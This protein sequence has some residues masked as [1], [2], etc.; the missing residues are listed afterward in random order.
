MGKKYFQNDPDFIQKGKNILKN[1]VTIEDIV[2]SEEK[3]K[4]SSNIGFIPIELSLDI[5]GMSGIKIYNQLRLNTDFLPYNYPKV[6]E[7]VVMGIN[8]KVDSSGWSTSIN[9]IAKP[10]S[11]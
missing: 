10:K 3:N 5:I 7:F 6:M 2:K 9:A 4:P 1:Y 11:E 8:H